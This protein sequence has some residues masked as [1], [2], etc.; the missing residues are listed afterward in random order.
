MPVIVDV[1]RKIRAL[2]K[3]VSGNSA[4]VQTLRASSSATYSI[5]TTATA[6]GTVTVAGWLQWQTLASAGA[7]LLR[8][9]GQPVA[10]ATPTGL[11]MGVVRMVSPGDVI[12]VVANSGTATGSYLAVVV[13]A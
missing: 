2:T 13:L 9:N 11:T 12:T 4:V 3:R 10:A 6:I 8:I 1:A 5:T 7:L